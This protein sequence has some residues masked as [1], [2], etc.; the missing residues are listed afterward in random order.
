MDVDCELCGLP[1][2]TPPIEVDDKPFC[3]IGCREV[4]LNF[5]PDILD[6]SASRSA[7]Q[8]GP[9]IPD[10]KE[11]FLRID[12]MHCSS[13]EILIERIAEGVDGILQARSSYATSTA[14]IVYDPDL[15]S[16]A[17]IPK[18]LKMIGYRARLST[19]DAPAYDYRPD[20]LRLLTGV[21]LAG[22]VMMLYVAFFYPVHLGVVDESEL[23]PILWLAHGVTPWAMFLFTTLLLVYVAA[24]IF[25]G[26]WIGW[27]ARVLNMDNL[28]TIAILAAYG[29]SVGQLLSGSVDLYFDVAATIIAVV[30]IGRHVE[31]NAKAEATQEL[32]RILDKWAPKARTRWGG[33]F[34][35]QD[36]E[37]LEP[38]DHV[39]IWEGEAI[40]VDGTIIYGHAA[41][42][43]ALMTGEPFPVTRD[44]GEQVLGGSVV[45][46]GTLE[47]KVGPL[48][49]SQMDNLAR[50]LWNLQSARSGAQS[51][52]DKVA[53]FFVPIVLVLAAMVTGGSLV[54]GA[55]LGTALLA[56][57]AT[58]IVSCPCT[59][60]LAIPLTTAIGVST[61]LRN[62]IIVTSADAFEKAPLI[63]IVAIDKT[64]TLSTGDMAV[65]DVLGP[66]EVTENAAAVERLSP[67]PI[68]RA[69]ARLDDQLVGEDLEIHPGKGATAMVGGKR[70]A[71][72]SRSLFAILGWDIPDELTSQAAAT[73]GDGV[74]SYVGWDGHVHG[75]IVTRDS[76]R[77]DW[78]QTVDRLRQHCRVVLLTG[79]EHPS[80]Y[81]ERVDTVFSG[82]PP[83]GKAAVIRQLRNE[84]TVVMIGDGSNDAPALAAADLGVAFGAPTSLAAEAADIIIPG[85]RLERLFTAFDLI[86]TIRGRMRQNLGWALM[87]NAIAIP[88][89]V[90]GLL[91]PLFAALAMSTSSLLVVW[92]SSRKIKITELSGE[93]E[94]R[95][96]NQIT[97]P[98]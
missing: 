39:I 46:E 65:V 16:E 80:G 2:P 82:I 60:G 92:N 55:E 71:V 76:S 86:H 27:R 49:E 73:P 12:G 74:I 37:E 89:A 94:T 33:E 40:P 18:A 54:F 50:I 53:R 61:A 31:R 78:Q 1:T 24:P 7:Q 77:P 95:P 43:E 96:I 84:G 56:G 90:T 75:V 85:D 9:V 14:K 23:E 44:P 83:E 68:A 69:I 52:A 97:G 66:A 98:R 57:M 36:I 91:N 22:L 6:L 32:S 64:G 4:Y 58:L 48:V 62:G 28:L 17:D 87:Y 10:G 30:T 93:H 25:R 13:C 15:I 88:L 35:F 59:F 20:L 34:R 29:Y 47:I 3:C 41:V 38:G 8:P 42:D 79:A 26:A 21:A 72:G 5:G 70:V 81:E 63:D 45:V 67:H 51:V 11:A 19:D